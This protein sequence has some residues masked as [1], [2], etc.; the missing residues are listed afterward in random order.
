MWRRRWFERA[1]KEYA[2][3]WII[4]GRQTTDKSVSNDGGSGQLG[5]ESGRPGWSRSDE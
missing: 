4:A 1:D 2:K 3:S 5:V